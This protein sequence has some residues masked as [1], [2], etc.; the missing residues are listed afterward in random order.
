MNTMAGLTFLMISRDDVGQA[1]RDNR[2]LQQFVLTD[3]TPTG[4]ILGT[5]SFGSVEEVRKIIPYQKNFQV[6]IISPWYNQG[7]IATLYI[8]KEG[9]QLFQWYVTSQYLWKLYSLLF[10]Y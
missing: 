8:V 3:V 4:R 7:H 10:S 5:G 2:E 9:M 1:F 6:A